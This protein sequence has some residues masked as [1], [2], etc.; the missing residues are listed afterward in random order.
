MRKKSNE[1]TLA[2]AMQMM[3]SEFRLGTELHERRI[4]SIWHAQMGKTISTY[5][6]G[7]AVRKNILY[8]SIISAPLK[9]ELSYSKDKI[10]MLINRELGEE[11]LED[12]VIR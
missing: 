1:T 11:Y 6:S 9:Q 3:L 7:I 8:L 4:Q 12:V 10:K 5:T 2:E